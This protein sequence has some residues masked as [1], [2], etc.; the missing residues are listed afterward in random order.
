VATQRV[1]IRYRRSGGFAGIE[2]AAEAASDEL[3]DEQAD[4]ARSLLAAPPGSS[5]SGAPGA[6]RFNYELH[7]DDGTRTE[8]FHWT[9][10]DVP[11]QARSLV[12][13]LNRLAHPV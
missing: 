12:S 4:A 11:D 10:A 3:P 2:L 7:L 5:S 8:T 9:D 1:H 13:T 6:D